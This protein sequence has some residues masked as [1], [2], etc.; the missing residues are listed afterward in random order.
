MVKVTRIYVNMFNIVRFNIVIFN[1]VRFNVFKETPTRAVVHR[2]L[3]LMNEN[4][5]TSV[6]F[7]LYLLSYH[8]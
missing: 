8:Q 4:L 7:N 2:N 6:T 3:T 1:I 5:Q